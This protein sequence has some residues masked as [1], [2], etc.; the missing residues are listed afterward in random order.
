MNMHRKG[1]TLIELMVVIAIISILSSVTLSIVKINRENAQT[2]TAIQDFVEIQKAL[3]FYYDKYGYYPPTNTSPSEWGGYWDVSN[4]GTFMP[5][6]AAEGFLK[7]VP[8]GRG[9]ITYNYFRTE[10]SDPIL[11][12]CLVDEDKYAYVLA[13]Y[14]LRPNPKLTVGDA[15]ENAAI[16]NP[17]CGSE[18]GNTTYCIIKRK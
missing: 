15:C 17:I 6:L 11:G 16:W 7:K 13:A 5:E 10:P 9:D 14:N 2:A 18:T 8:V 12:Y 4:V 1:F 3:E